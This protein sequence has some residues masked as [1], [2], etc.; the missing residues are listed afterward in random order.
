M[1]STSRSAAV[2]SRPRGPSGRAAGRPAAA[3]ACGRSA[4]S[5]L[6]GSVAVGVERAAAPRSS[7]T[8]SAIWRRVRRLEER[9]ARRCRRGPS[10][11]HLQDDRGQ[12]GAQDLRVG[13]LRPRRR[14][15]PR[16]TAGCRCRRRRGRSGPAAG[17][18]WPARS[19]RSA[20]AAPWCAGCSARSARCRRRRRSGCPARSAR[21]RRRWWPAR[22]GARCA[23]PKTRCCSAADS[24]R[25]ERQDL[26]V[27]QRQAARARSAASRI[28]RSPG[29]KTRMSPRRPRSTARRRRRTIAGR[30]GRGRRRRS[31]AGVAERAVAD[32][33]RVGAAGH[34]DDRR[35]RAVASAKCSAKRSGSI[36]AEVMMT[37]RSGRRGSSC[38]R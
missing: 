14:S 20:A 34:L 13:E 12:V 22:S 16:R 11:G 27:R 32:L 4:V 25:V 31:V 37:L 30:P 24:R 29:R 15:P 38:L 3:R 26:G 33:D 7:R 35:R 6:R 9:E 10:D 36:V 23:R 1:T 5:R 2:A 21:S 8:P 18:R 19:A 17:W 28:S